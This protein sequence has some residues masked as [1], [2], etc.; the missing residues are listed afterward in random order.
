LRLASGVVLYAYLVTHFAN[1][2][3]GNVSLAAMEEG[4]EYHV[5]VWQS[6]LGTLLL[7]SALTIHAALGCGRFTSAATFAG[8]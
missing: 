6:L 3:L 7:Y 5:I 1:H 2:A 4:L 8:A